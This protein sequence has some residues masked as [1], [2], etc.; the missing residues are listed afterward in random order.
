MCLFIARMA[1]A[2]SCIAPVMRA[3]PVHLLTGAC[4]QVPTGGAPYHPEC[5]WS[6][7]SA[8][9]MVMPSRGPFASQ[10]LNDKQLHP[11]AR[12]IRVSPQELMRTVLACHTEAIAAERGPCFQ[13]D[14]E[15]LSRLTFAFYE[16]VRVTHADSD[17]ARACAQTWHTIL[18]GDFVR[19]AGKDPDG[20]CLCARVIAIIRVQGFRR[21][22]V[23]L[24]RTWRHDTA[25]ARDEPDRTDGDL[26]PRAYFVLVRHLAA[27]VATAG[28]RDETGRPICPGLTNNHAL[29]T[30]AKTA[31]PRWMMRPGR[32]DAVANDTGLCTDRIRSEDRAHLGCYPLHRISHQLAVAEDP[33][34]TDASIRSHGF[35]ETVTI[36]VGPGRNNQTRVDRRSEADED[37]DSPC[38]DL[39][40]SDS[41]SDTE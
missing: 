26:Q 25:S 18:A 32:I 11:I 35:L 6:R 39:L 15:A 38:D 40:D 3:K 41:D 37:T 27:H 8:Q 9:N 30:W 29:W 36:P 12:Q 7:I 1:G 17:H 31:A 16:T 14:W 23:P 5:A 20:T 24:P 28:A 19:P 2:R 10:S 34:T 21:A 33:D 4:F 13:G 22:G